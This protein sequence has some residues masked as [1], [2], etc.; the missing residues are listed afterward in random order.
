MIRHSLPG[1]LFALVC[2]I[3]CGSSQSDATT[4]TQPGGGTGNSGG[5]TSLTPSAG[6]SGVGVS[7]ASTG[8][9]GGSTAVAGSGG[10]PAAGVTTGGAGPVGGLRVAVA[11]QQV[12]GARPLRA[13][14]VDR[15]ASMPVTH[16]LRIRSTSLQPRIAMCTTYKVNPHASTRA[17]QQ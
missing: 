13:A 10:V 2:T 9:A 5:G 6:S 1:G 12:Q 17:F 15:R 3:A 8:G 4:A 11:S 7:G 14:V 16:L